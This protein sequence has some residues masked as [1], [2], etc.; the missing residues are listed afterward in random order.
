MMDTSETY[1]KMCEKAEEIQKQKQL[2]DVEDFYY[3]NT[4]LP[5]QD[6]LQEMVLKPAN[7]RIDSIYRYISFLGIFMA[8]CLLFDSL[9]KYQLAFVMKEKYG[10]IW[11]GGEWQ[12]I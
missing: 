11:N 7:T 10:K 5:R 8:T 1:V 2:F 4:W 6:Q 9:E 3:D 12:I